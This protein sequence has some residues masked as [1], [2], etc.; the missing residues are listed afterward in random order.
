MIGLK[1]HKF[2]VEFIKE[3]DV[4]EDAEKFRQKLYKDYQ[5][6]LKEGSVVIIYGVR[7]EETTSS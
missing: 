1:R 2:V 5:E 3:F 6:E 7:N 4:F